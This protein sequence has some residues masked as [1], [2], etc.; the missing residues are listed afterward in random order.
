MDFS[1]LCPFTD[2]KKK[3]S[4]AKDLFKEFYT[5]VYELYPCKNKHYRTRAELSFYHSDQALAYAMFHNKKKIIIDTLDF[6]DKK[7][8]ALMPLLLGVFN[9]NEK[10]R[11]KLFGIEFLTTNTECSVTL[12][13][14]KNIDLI[15]QELKNLNDDLKI[16]IIARSKGKKLVFGK[17]ILKQCLEIFGKK[18]FYVFNNDC[19]IQPNTS[20]NQTMIEWMIKQVQNEEKCDMLELYCGYGNFTLA[21]APF[22][23]KILASELSKINISF[24]IEN[25]NLNT[26][27]NITFARLSSEDLK[28]A[29]YKERKFFRLKEIHLDEFNFTHILIDPPRCGLS[30]SVKTLVQDYKNILYLSCNP[31]SLKKDLEILKKTHT[32]VNIAFF[33]QFHNTTHLECAVVLKKY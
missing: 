2:F 6:V 9:S 4:F 26:I 30:E 1:K 7:I 31:L 20:M 17:E 22:F 3:V 25:C 19:F 27:S 13:Y 21:L 18:F 24:A 5:G 15:S 29:F 33:D 10:L 23:R 14:H 11:Q 28:K 16:N 8:S 32:V 12:L